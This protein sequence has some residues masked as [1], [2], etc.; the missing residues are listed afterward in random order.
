MV[1]HLYVFD[2]SIT[3]ELTLQK[4][5]KKTALMDE[6]QGNL[7]P[8]QGHTQLKEGEGKNIV[9]QEFLELYILI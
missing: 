2:L 3:Q 8:H 9:V 7:N 4:W 6:L 1:L 5:L